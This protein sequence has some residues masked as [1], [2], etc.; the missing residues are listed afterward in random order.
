MT[1]TGNRIEN[2]LVTNTDRGIEVDVDGNF[3]IRNTASG[4][5]TAFSITGTQT[6]GLIITATGTITTTNPGKGSE[7]G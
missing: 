5:T 6:I 7:R 3:I 2:N 1:G 4:N